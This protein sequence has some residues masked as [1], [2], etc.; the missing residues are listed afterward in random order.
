MG[1]SSAT[2]GLISAAISVL[3]IAVMQIFKVQIA[4][5]QLGTIFGGFLGSQLFVFLLTA[6]S[7]LEVSTFGAGFQAR[8]FPEIAF[9]MLTALF[10]SS[11]VHRV[12]IT[13]CILFSLG[14]LYY[15]NR[16]S[17]TLYGSATQT[18]GIKKKKF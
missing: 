17:N 15:L 5:T 10:V 13:T 4:A 14:S 11:T 7:N 18:Q 1:V 2:S 8:V 3:I 12:C 6:V 9:T 16:I